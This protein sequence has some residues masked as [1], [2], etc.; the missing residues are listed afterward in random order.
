MHSEEFPRFCRDDEECGRQHRSSLILIGFPQVGKTTLGKALAQRL[1]WPFID[2]DEEIACVCGMG[3]SDKREVFQHLGEE[4]FRKCERDVI[5]NLSLFTPTV[6]ATGGGVVLDQK[7]RQKLAQQGRFLYLSLS[8]EPLWQRWSQEPLPI[9][10]Q[11]REDWNA[12]Y[13]QRDPIYRAC[14]DRILSI[15]GLNKETVVFRL[16]DYVE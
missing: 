15:D 6:L 3:G 1:A 4:K 12:F 11:N 9:I 2:T 7:N 14:S 5:D 10:L 8:K 13:T 16:M